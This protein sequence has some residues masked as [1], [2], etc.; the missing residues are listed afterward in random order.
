MVGRVNVDFF[1]FGR[2]SL[3]GAQADSP[4][5][6]GSINTKK[7][8]EARTVQVRSV[9]ARKRDSRRNESP[10]PRAGEA[11][12]VGIPERRLVPAFL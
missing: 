6:P 5:S 2:V 4:V 11:S 1:F 9:Y 3:E 7:G 12:T 8:R 10:P